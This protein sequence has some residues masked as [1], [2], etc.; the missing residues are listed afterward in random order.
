MCGRFCF[1]HT[2]KQISDRYGVSVPALFSPTYNAAPSQLLP[3][4]SNAT[5]GVLSFYRWGLIPSWSKNASLGA[6]MINARMESLTQKPSFK[7]LFG[8]RHCLVPV[9]GFYEWSGSGRTRTPFFITTKEHI[10]SLAG[11]WDSWI[12][13]E[14]QL[15]VESFTI[16]TREANDFMRPIHDR[17]PL[18]MKPEKEGD[19]LDCDVSYESLCSCGEN[20][21]FT[22]TEV[23]TEVNSPAANHPGLILPVGGR[24]FD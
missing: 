24:L 4:I 7:N 19:W 22:A 1:I 5:K 3:V 13:P 20:I 12:D 2:P 11:L 21:D 18:I 9:S 16:I 8:K 17:M 14:T 15:S 10:F 6:K 23:S